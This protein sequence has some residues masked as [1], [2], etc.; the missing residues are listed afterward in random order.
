MWDLIPRVPKGQPGLLHAVPFGDP[1]KNPGRLG[2]LFSLLCLLCSLWLNKRLQSQKTHISRGKPRSLRSRR[3][4][5]S[6]GFAQSG[7]AWYGR[8]LWQSS[9]KAGRRWRAF[10]PFQVFSGR[11]VGV[12]SQAV[13]LARADGER[14]DQ[15]S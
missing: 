13:L 15:K 11:H 10:T 12:E 6:I 14:A 5:A 7:K 4:V 8:D 9:T 2:Q 1:G 3:S